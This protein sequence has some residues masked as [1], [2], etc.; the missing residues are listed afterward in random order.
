MRKIGIGI[1][2]IILAYIVTF[3]GIIPAVEWVVATNF[4]LG[5][6]SD[7]KGEGTIEQI[8]ATAYEQCK[9][10]AQQNFET[11]LGVFPS[12]DYKGWLIGEDTYLIHSSI[13][14]QESAGT[15][16]RNDYTCK[17]QLTGDSEYDQENWTLLGLEF[18]KS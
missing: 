16:H 15:P 7:I 17:I 2:L 9:D 5:S 10:H 6:S 13:E 8:M 4:G 12:E 3:Q 11:S 18:T 14:V 1:L